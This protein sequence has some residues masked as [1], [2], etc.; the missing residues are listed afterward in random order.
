MRKVSNGESVDV[1]VCWGGG[2]RVSGN[3]CRCN[4]GDVYTGSALPRSEYKNA[5]L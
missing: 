5:A 4:S 1:D 2:G 3:V